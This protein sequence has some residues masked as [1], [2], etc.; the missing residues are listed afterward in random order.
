MKKWKGFIVGIA[1]GCALML[2]VTAYGQTAKEY[3]LKT[4]TYPIVVNGDTYVSEDLPI[5]N[6]EGHTYIP[7]RSVGDLLGATVEWNEEAFQAEITY[8]QEEA[9]ENT[10]F[11]QVQASGSNGS[12]TITGEAR[13]FE[14]SMSYAVSD[15]HNYLLESHHTLDAGAPAW[16]P[17]EL[18]IELEPEQIP[19][20]GTLMIELFEYSANDGSKINVLNILLES[21]VS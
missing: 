21:F 20:N 19:Q 1:T 18:S 14:A 17:F 16:S 11:R 12:Y 3:V 9:I 15:G 7:M 8:G 6:Y 5:L 10:A 4:V 2:T 13:I